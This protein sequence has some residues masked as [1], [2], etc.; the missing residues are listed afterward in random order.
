MSSSV[1]NHAMRIRFIDPRLFL[2]IALGVAGV[3]MLAAPGS[4]PMFQLLR[5]GIGREIPPEALL[6][7]EADAGPET[8][9]TLTARAIFEAAAHSDPRPSLSRAIELDPDE[10]V[11]RLL[12]AL[13]ATGEPMMLR[14]EPEGIEPLIEELGRVEALDR[15]NA[16][17]IF[18]R[19]L[20]LISVDRF[21]EAERAIR[22]SSSEPLWRSGLDLLNGVGP[23]VVADIYGN[24][25]RRIFAAAR[26]QPMISIRPAEEAVARYLSIFPGDRE[27]EIE[28]R[29]ERTLQISRLALLIRGSR[30]RTASEQRLSDQMLGY[31]RASAGLLPPGVELPEHQVIDRV[32]RTVSPR[33]G[34]LHVLREQR[35][36]LARSGMVAL[37]GTYL[38]MLWWAGGLALLLYGIGALL[39][40]F[41]PP[42]GLR[43]ADESF[44]AL[45]MTRL[46]WIGGSGLGAVMLIGIALTQSA[47]PS[48][49]WSSAF[50]WLFERSVLVA[51]GG[52]LLALVLPYHWHRRGMVVQPLSVALQVMMVA[53][54]IL[55]VGYSAAI[56][57]EIANIG[58]ALQTW[59]SPPAELS[60][61]LELAQFPIPM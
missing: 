14:A 39:F 35:N 32:I 13:Y 18:Y 59:Y 51:F 47:T 60:L 55:L 31:V 52:A 33:A 1:E 19:A 38:W 27:L 57:P 10:P 49:M 44:P 22:K 16:V 36:L 30:S 56:L 17:P 61:P 58:G 42:G 45:R 12:H 20:L 40:G 29:I 8:A 37:G 2:T 26:C 23:A 5:Q 50:R 54:G 4:R 3:C 28:V 25:L 24:D 53:T 48:G 34:Y 43:Y 15:G 21:A 41:L 46:I 6:W 7:Q 11:W 9:M